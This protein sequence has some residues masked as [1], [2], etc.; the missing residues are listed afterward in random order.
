MIDSE[1]AMVKFLN[2]IAA[3]PDIS[4]VPIMIDS[5]RGSVLEAGL[6]CVQGKGI[7]N[8]ISLKGGEEEFLRQALLVRRYGAAVVVMAFDEEGQAVTKDKKVAI[9][10]RAYKLLTEK[11]G[12]QPEDISV[13]PDFWTDLTRTDSLTGFGN[14]HA[15]FADLEE[16][17]AADAL[18]SVLAIFNTTYG[19]PVTR[20]HIYGA[21]CARTAVSSTPTSTSTPEAFSSSTPAPDTRGSGSMVPT[22]TFDT[23]AS[24]IAS[25]QGPVR[26][27]WEQGSS[28]TTIVEPRAPSPARRNASISACDSPG[29][30]V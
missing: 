25:T 12:F 24:T 15:L 14:R 27:S 20:C 22:I 2:L 6:R 4:R 17:T 7:V 29:T 13:A 23:P 9:C 26:P 5:S 19:R 8:S 10:R 21:S 11:A 30:C 18:S 28:V 1:A 16:A 3:E